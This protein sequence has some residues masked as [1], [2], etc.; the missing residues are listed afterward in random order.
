MSFTNQSSF[1]KMRKFKYHHFY[2]IPKNHQLCS[3]PYWSI[4]TW[5][6]NTKLHISTIFPKN[7]KNCLGACSNRISVWVTMFLQNKIISISSFYQVAYTSYYNKQVKSVNLRNCTFNTGLLR[8]LTRHT[9]QMLSCLRH[10][11]CPGCLTI[12]NSNSNLGAKVHYSSRTQMRS[13][14]NSLNR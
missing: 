11:S 1:K 12:S 2:R 9:K 7:T 3:Q 14:I 10:K 8:L 5:L 6:S 4:Q 13:I